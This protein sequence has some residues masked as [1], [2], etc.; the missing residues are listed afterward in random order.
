MTR[1][2]SYTCLIE[3]NSVKNMIGVDE[4]LVGVGFFLQKEIS[5]CA[6][7]PFVTKPREMGVRLLTM[8]Y[9]GKTLLDTQTIK[10]CFGLRP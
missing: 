3:L 2:I 9:L 8:G 4:R 1:L 7:N 6:S 10:G 5:N